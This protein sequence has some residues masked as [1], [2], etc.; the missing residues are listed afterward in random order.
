MLDELLDL[1][2]QHARDGNAGPLADDFGDVFLVDLFLQHA[3]GAG[4]AVLRGVQLLQ[5]GFELGQF[6]V[7][8]LRGAV[9]LALAG[10]LLGLEAQG[11]DLLFQ[12]ADAVDGFALFGP[13][14]AQ[15]RRSARADCAT[16]RSTSCEP[17]LA[18]GVGFALE[19]GALDF[20]RRGLALQL[21]DLGGHGA[22]L[23]GERSGGFVD[24]VDG[25]VGQEAVADV[26][27]R[28][29]GRG[30]N[31]RILDAHV[32][33]LLVAVFQAAQNGDRVFDV[34]LA[35][36]DD[37]EAALEGRVLLDVLA[38]LVERGCADG[39]Q[40]AARQRRLEHVAGV[41]GAL[42]RAR[43]DER[44]QLVDEEHDLAVAIPRFP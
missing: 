17:L 24:Q 18:V 38:V 3:R 25:L 9:E 13:A 33:V 23:D 44:V 6:A 5:L 8:D 2:L 4:F 15:G 21:I 1:A 7:L 26:A 29:R 14:G 37:L 28:E 12:F 39:A 31:G 11:L 34:G 19:R 42:G 22:D 30:D 20:E 10:L 27:V 16:S 36:V 35:H 40:F 43:A 41:D 32:V